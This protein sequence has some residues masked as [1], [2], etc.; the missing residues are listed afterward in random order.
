MAASFPSIVATS[1]TIT[2]SSP[3]LDAKSVFEKSLR[4]ARSMSVVGAV[5]A[6]MIGAGVTVL[7]FQVVGL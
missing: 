6:L 5:G 1:L 3:A 4:K 7:V 2:I